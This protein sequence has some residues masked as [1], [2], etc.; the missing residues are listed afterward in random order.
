MEQKERPSDRRPHCLWSW[1]AALF[2]LASVSLCAP[3]LLPQGW[4]SRHPASHPPIALLGLTLS[5]QPPHLTDSAE[6]MVTHK[7]I[8]GKGGGHPPGSLLETTQ[9][10]LLGSLQVTLGTV[11]AHH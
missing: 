10:G 7:C 9:L 5:P 11:L 4:K 2:L 3:T 8:C 1:S 6:V